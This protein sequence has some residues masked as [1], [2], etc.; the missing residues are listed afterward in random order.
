[1]A[2]A[3]AKNLE[4]YKD[5]E[6]LTANQGK[7]IVM[8]Y[9]GAIR[10]LRIALENMTHRTYDVVNTNVIKAQEI[11]TELM[12]SLNMDEG[13]EIAQNLLNLYAYMKKRLLEGNINK[14]PAVLEEIVGLLEQL[15]G[16]WEDAAHKEIT[17]PQPVQKGEPARAGFSIQG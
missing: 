8:L 11:I 13:G 16:A 17:R 2:T 3:K 15:K 4:A 7:L 5:T 14:D 1:M 6:I 12:L 10:F 9:E